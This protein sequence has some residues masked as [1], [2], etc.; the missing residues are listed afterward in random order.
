MRPLP[1]VTALA[2]VCLA[3]LASCEDDEGCRP[4]T[5]VECTCKD[6]S[7]GTRYCLSNRTFDDC[8]CGSNEPWSSFPQAGGGDPEPETSWNPFDASSVFD[9]LRDAGVDAGSSVMSD[10]V[11]LSKGPGALIDV[12]AHGEHVWVVVP[13][14]VSRIA[15]ED[16]SE[17]ARWQ[18]PRPLSMAAF[19]GERL[20]VLD[21]AKLT[22]LEPEQL[23]E[24]LSVNLIEPCTAALLMAGGPLVCT[25]G[26]F[27]GAVYVIDPVSG[28]QQS[29]ARVFRSGDLLEVPGTRRFLVVDTS[30]SS[31][32]PS[33]FELADGGVPV[34]LDAG[35][36]ISASI[37]IGTPVGFDAVPA[38]NL[39]T[40]QGI[41]LRMDDTCSPAGEPCLTR[42]G[43][44]GLL[45]AQESFLAMDTVG[46]A[47][48]GLLE[49]SN[50]SGFS[51]ARCAA[52]PCRLLNIDVA[53][54][55]IRAEQRVLRPLRS[56]IAMHVLP[57]QSAAVLGVGA[58]GNNTF[59]PFNADAGYEVVR[60]DMEA[61]E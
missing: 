59:D 41:L 58:V 52:Q 42:T 22:M 11:L 6:G 10:G 36:Q 18:A 44:L 37:S 17:L 60:L 49:P 45:G 5:E 47:L 56:V 39:V 16:G 33:V 38:E 34:A 8:Y 54:R 3:L 40:R 12:F 14:G 9:P 1:P 23:E 53:A 51:A 20:A 35:N 2:A 50:V 27:N 19:D 32:L 57:E 25:P 4:E 15:L 61:A 7:E 31:L 30:G 55:T 24:Q 46:D 29:S 21:G 48:F 28:A 13:E 26:A 43:T